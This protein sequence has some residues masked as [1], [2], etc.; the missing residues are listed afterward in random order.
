ML[1]PVKRP[2]CVVIWNINNKL[3]FAVLRALIY[4]WYNMK[5]HNSFPFNYPVT[6]RAPFARISLYEVNA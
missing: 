4:E 6:L 5:L 1:Q 3:K 2:M